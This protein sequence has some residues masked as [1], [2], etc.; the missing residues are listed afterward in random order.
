MTNLHQSEC[1][2]L[3]LRR[4]SSEDFDLLAASLERIEVGQR[5]CLGRPG[6]DCAFV[7]FP[8]TGFASVTAQCD[9][10]KVEIGLVGREGFLGIPI[11]LGGG[12]WPSATYAQLPGTFLRMEAAAFREALEASPSLTRLLLRYVQAYLVQVSSTAVANATYNVVERLARWLLMA[13][14][15]TD[16]PELVLTHEIL[17]IML[18]VRRPGVTVATHLLEGDHAIRATRGRIDVVS[19]AKLIEAAG[20]SYG[21]AEAE[22][23]RL[24]GSQAED[25]LGSAGVGQVATSSERDLDGYSIL[26]VEDDYGLARDTGRAVMEAGGTVL[27]PV[28]REDQALAIVARRTPRCAL[29]DINL[30]GGARFAVADALEERGVPFVFVT[31][32]DDEAIP[33]RFDRVPRLRKPVELPRIV[34][35]AARLCADPR[36]GLPDGARAGL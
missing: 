21:T 13:S 29:V 25:R 16:G 33:A 12:S 10:M 36:R 14:D 11:L 30:G 24:V 22:Y 5:D 9:P 15:R 6:L 19:R 35:V 23:D 1:R 20:A 7:Y 28:G 26:V 34:Q 4:M 18:G 27:G 2:N 8:E 3:L 17:S 31:A 32:Y